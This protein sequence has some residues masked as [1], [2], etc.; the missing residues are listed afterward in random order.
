MNSPKRKV[1]DLLPSEAIR[2]SPS[3]DGRVFDI[4]P[5]P[6]EAEKVEVE[7]TV[8]LSE[9][10]NKLTPITNLIAMIENGLLKGS[11]EMHDLVLK[12]LEQS[13]INIAE[14]TRNP[15]TK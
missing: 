10:R 14:L 9:V 11:I 6:T 15:E 8:L 4:E 12:E 5:I 2:V 13:K 3:Q 1:T 7:D